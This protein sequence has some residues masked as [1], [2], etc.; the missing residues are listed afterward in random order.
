[1]KKSNNKK[2]LVLF[3]LA[4]AVLTILISS[5]FAGLLQEWEW[6]TQDMRFK[7]RGSIATDS[8]L[9]MID[10]ND[11]SA[12][13]Y[14]RWPWKRSVHAKLIELLKN[15]NVKTIAYDVLFAKPVDPA[16][17]AALIKATRSYEPLIF[18]MVSGLTDTPSI[19]PS[20]ENPL[21]KD[22]W[23]ASDIVFPM[24]SLKVDH[25][26]HIAANRDA[27]GVIRRVPLLIHL[28]DKKMPSLAFQA[29]LKYLDLSLSSIKVS[30]HWITLP[31]HPEETRIPIDEKGQ[32]L[33]NYAG[34]W[35]E[36]FEHASFA[37][38]LSKQF[39]NIE[40]L[41]GKLILVANTMTGTDIKSIPFEKD[42]PG[43]GVH[44]NIINTILTKN[45]LK[46]T[47]KSTNHTL[48][49]M[50]CIGA[51]FLFK[52]R[53]YL[54]Q[55][56]TVFG[57]VLAYSTTVFLLFS[58]GIV[59]PLVTPVMGIFLT[60]FLLVSYK[61]GTEKKA[62]DTLGEEKKQLES[63]LESISNHLKNK[64]DELTAIKNQL[65]TLQSGMSERDAFEKSQAEKVREL[66]D[67][68]ETIMADRKRLEAKR[69]ELEN[70]VLDLRVN[71]TFDEPVEEK[72]LTNECARYNLITK[73]QEVLEL[74]EILK[75]VASVPTSVLITGE[76]GTGKELFARA[77]HQMSER[78]GSFV[79]V[80]LGAVPESL[81]ESE[82]FGHE[83]G[84]FTGAIQ[85]RK[86]KFKEAEGG[87]IFLDEIGE[88]SKGI[89]VKLLRAIQEKEIQPVGGQSFKLD[90]RIIAATNRN[91]EDEVQ[92]DQFREDLF[93]RINTVTL[94]LPPLRERKKDI[95]LLV[96]HFVKKYGNEYGKPVQGL[97]DK[98]MQRLLDYEWPGNIR[99]L[100][101]V[102]QRG[103]TF[104]GGDIIQEKDLGLNLKK[105]VHLELSDGDDLLLKRLR[106]CSFEIN[107]TAAQLK[108]NRN[109]VSSRF[110][111]ICFDLLV[112]HQRVV[113]KVV[114]EIVDND[115]DSKTVEQKVNEYY[116]NLIR[117]ARESSSEDDAIREALRRSKNVPTR[118]HSSIELLVKSCF[119]DEQNEF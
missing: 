52:G 92:K 64:N 59:L 80:N 72:A 89:Q 116:E 83:K 104:S 26:G 68:M 75:K 21:D 42:Y 4:G 111:G 96:R 112:K 33:I 53:N 6:K 17:D 58:S 60:A 44:A 51:A 41:A 38:V 62:L 97:S 22:Y 98:A 56:G 69:A 13:V 55:T 28:D 100:E 46:E 54:I 107:A 12:E 70:K 114:D 30:K 88:S 1:M 82:L 16:E 101:N 118:H 66:Q 20:P 110:K 18:P 109:T 19:Q 93:F 7:W 25:L 103:I 35:Q 78:K 34:R 115:V 67:K 95:E 81:I 3:G 108:M 113:E 48:I 99:E 86:G 5:L 87:T 50:L 39:G 45:F 76:S 9:I 32:L 119:E 31:T 29:V 49:L 85:T 77:L 23:F 84:A 117:I 24:K 27:D 2:Q 74:F 102:V 57:L 65:N 61:A 15:S 37:S 11:S 91:L 90:I 63:H 10:A 71:I 47:H 40:N 8:S 105:T 43:A 106:D 79:A 94:E 73:T 14:G 36:T